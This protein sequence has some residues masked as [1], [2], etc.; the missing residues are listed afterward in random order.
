MRSWACPLRARQARVGGW[1]ISA[2]FDY[3]QVGLGT[4]GSQATAAAAPCNQHPPADGLGWGAH[5]DQTA[6]RTMGQVLFCTPRGQREPSGGQE[7]PWVRGG[8]G[9]PDT[10]ALTP[11]APWLHEEAQC[12]L[13][14]C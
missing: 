7:G 13:P 2:P 4:R 6:W 12:Q 9:R 1:P 3:K 14:G 11:R 5:R 10:S 8:Y